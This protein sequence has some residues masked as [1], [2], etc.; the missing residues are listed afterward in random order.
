MRSGAIWDIW[1]TDLT[2]DEHSA[3]NRNRMILT[4]DE[5]R[6]TRILQEETEATERQKNLRTL[7]KLSWIV[8][9]IDTDKRG[10]GAPASW[11]ARETGG[12]RTTPWTIPQFRL[13]LEL[14]CWAIIMTP[15]TPM[16]SV[17]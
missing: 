6:W 7:R 14:P 11:L 1:E 4:T 12:P 8:V 9:R 16:D 13:W 2:T 17:F 5:H 3:E 10:E 15:P